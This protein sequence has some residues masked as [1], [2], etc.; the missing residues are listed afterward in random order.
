MQNSGSDGSGNKL[1]AGEKQLADQNISVS[2]GRFQKKN[3]YSLKN[4][5]KLR[6]YFLE[7]A[8]VVT[9]EGLVFLFA[10]MD[11]FCSSHERR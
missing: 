6:Q 5:S 9:R 2:F 8:T 1:V 3:P 4:I 10:Q 7:E 11:F